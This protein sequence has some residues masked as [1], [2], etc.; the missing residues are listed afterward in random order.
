MKHPLEIRLVVHN[1]YI[2]QRDA[3][4]RKTYQLLP[5]VLGVGLP[6]YQPAYEKAI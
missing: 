3:L 6:T 1:Q 5:T 2:H 4:L